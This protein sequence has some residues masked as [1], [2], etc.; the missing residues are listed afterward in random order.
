MRKKLVLCLGSGGI[1]GFAHLGVYQ[2]LFENNIPISAVYG[3]SVGSLV[4]SFICDAW[5]PKKLIETAL[6][7]S[8]F[9]LDFVWPKNGYI[10]GSKLNQFI[11]KNISQKL[12]E[13]LKTPLTVVATNVKTGRGNYFTSG[14][15]SDC[16]QASCSIPNVFRPVLIDGVEYLDGDLASPV[17]M[18]KARLDHGV[19]AVIIGVNIIANMEQ[20]PRDHRK[21]ARWVSKDS[22]RRTIVSHEKQFADIY[23]EPDIEYENKFSIEAA[24]QRIHAGYLSTLQTIPKLKQILDTV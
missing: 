18:Q 23:I 13:D 6:K 2:A 22:Y 17:P 8:P 12:I 19:E 5:E 3:T 20:A 4:G 21:W 14:I 24:R 1:R 16:I 15:L 10:K 11:Q 9:M 7:I